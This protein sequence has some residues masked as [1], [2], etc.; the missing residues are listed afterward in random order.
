CDKG[1]TKPIVLQGVTGSG[2]TEVYL[3][4]AAH[5][6]KQGRGVLILVP[7]ISLT[8]GVSSINRLSGLSL[9]PHW[10]SG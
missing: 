10:A 4:A 1:D 7:E 9:S 6:L 5:V 3:Q 2:K 8:A